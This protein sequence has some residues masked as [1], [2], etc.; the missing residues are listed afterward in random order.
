M[1]NKIFNEINSNTNNFLNL[2]NFWSKLFLKR[3]F[4]ILPAFI[5]ITGCVKQ[6]GS[7]RMRKELANIYE[8]GLENPSQYLHMNRSRPA[9]ENPDKFADFWGEFDGQSLTTEP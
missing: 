1:I 8:E 4:P 3:L 5:L 7:D 2:F 9:G 6:Q